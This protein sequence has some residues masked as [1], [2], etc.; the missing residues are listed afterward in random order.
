MS[1]TLGHHPKPAGRHLGDSTRAL[2]S[3]HPI[4]PAGPSELSCSAAILER[5]ETRLFGCRDGRVG[6]WDVTLR[7]GRTVGAEMAPLLLFLLLAA[8]IGGWVASEFQ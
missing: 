5:G 3:L 1:T 4:A 2:F 7:R 6:W 8:L